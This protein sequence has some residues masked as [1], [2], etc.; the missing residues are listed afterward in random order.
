M[1]LII[2]L[3][4]EMNYVFPQLELTGVN[5]GLSIAH[6][7]TGICWTLI[8]NLSVATIVSNPD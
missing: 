3:V 2:K 7:R 5:K 6:S 8:L 4:V 1:Y